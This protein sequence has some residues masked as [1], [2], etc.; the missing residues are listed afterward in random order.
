[1]SNRTVFDLISD[2]AADAP[3]AVAI[4]ALG[5]RPLTYAMLSREIRDGVITAAAAREMY[6]L[7]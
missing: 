2:R 5:R 1:M 6:G 7:D 4:H 3:G